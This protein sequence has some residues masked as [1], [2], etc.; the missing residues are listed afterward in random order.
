MA[1][2]SLAALVYPGD[3]AH[4][5]AA[6]VLLLDFCQRLQGAGWRVGGLVQQRLPAP[7]S[8]GKPPLGLTDLRT[9]QTFPISQKLG[10]LSRSCSL[11]PGAIAQA[12]SALRQALA[13]RVQLAV[14]NR[15]GEL[16]ATGGGYVAEIAALADVGVPVLTVLAS[17]HL[18]AWRRFTGGLGAELPPQQ[19][20]LRH[21][22]AQA[23]GREVPA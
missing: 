19:D 13:D 14:T 7:G 22:L 1:T 16:E 9:G 3:M 15:F 23:T 5:D 2:H 6:D 17:K 21:W 10:P 4:G 11:D 8:G 20:A 18:D 12:S